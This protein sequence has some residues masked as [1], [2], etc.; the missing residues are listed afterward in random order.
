MPGQDE[1]QD[2]TLG[3]P[4]RREAHAQGQQVGRHCDEPERGQPQDRGHMG[5]SQGETRRQSD[6]DK[7]QTGDGGRRDVIPQAV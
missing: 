3:A 7:P 2:R 1:L 5:G 6:R 4:R